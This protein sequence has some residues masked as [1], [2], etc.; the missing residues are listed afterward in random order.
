MQDTTKTFAAAL[1]A[2]LPYGGQNK[3]SD[4]EQNDGEELPRK[5]LFELPNTPATRVDTSKDGP[6]PSKAIKHESGREEK[7]NA[8]QVGPA[9][10]RLCVKRGF[11]KLVSLC[12]Y[13]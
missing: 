9:R 3:K 2:P 13:L 10:H 12:L 8:Y 1:T 7:E 6:Q 11:Q 4:K 5:A